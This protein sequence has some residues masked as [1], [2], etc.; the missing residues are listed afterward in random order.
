M[1][2]LTFD[3]LK[4]VYD[5]EKN[6]RDKPIFIDFYADWWGPCKVFE[7]VLNK[8]IPEY[9]SKIDSY[10]VDISEEEKLAIMFGARSI[11]YM[12]FISKSGDGAKQLGALDEATLKYYFEGL[13]SKK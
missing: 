7:Q 6:L 1:N 13:I 9:K 12:I 2:K 4:N 8:V 11:P 5:G 10:K 3:E